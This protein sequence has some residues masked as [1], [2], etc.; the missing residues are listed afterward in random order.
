[1]TRSTPFVVALLATVAAAA[2]AA[3]PAV[4]Q[5]PHAT[6][7]P[8]M[9]TPQEVVDRMLQIAEVTKNDLKIENG[10]VVAYRTRVQLS[11]KYEA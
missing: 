2:V 3:G 8:Y 5:D 6:L 1:M 11:F 10:K 9:A 7:A 4:P